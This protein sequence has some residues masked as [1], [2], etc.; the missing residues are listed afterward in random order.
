MNGIQVTAIRE[1]P[2]EIPVFVRLRMEERSRVDDIRNLYV[3]SLQ[4]TQRVPLGVVSS[5][6]YRMQT[7]KIRAR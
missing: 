7:E 3:Y 5:V 2:D 1:E 6:T 4:S